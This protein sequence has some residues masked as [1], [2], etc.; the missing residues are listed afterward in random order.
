[1]RNKSSDLTTRQKEILTYIKQY[2]AKN[3]YTPSI[4]NICEHFNLSSSATVKVHLDGII[5]KGFLRRDSRNPRYLEI[6]VPNEFEQSNNDVVSVPLLGKITA[7]NPIEAIETPDEYFPL[8]VSLI[9]NNKEI[10]ILRVSGE[11]MI[12]AGIHDNDIIIV[13]RVNTAKNGDIVVAMNDENEVTL[14]TFYKEKNYFRLQP[15]NDFMAP[16]ILKNVSILG[17]AIGLYRKI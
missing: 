7:G 11:S 1:M 12:N 9:P 2:Y 13:E 14:K 3:K 4:R 10:F 6:M 5:E 15:E 8:P 16:I 17:K